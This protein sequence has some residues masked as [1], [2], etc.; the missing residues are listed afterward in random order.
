M[1]VGDRL[2]FYTDGLVENSGADG[3]QITERTIR[4][5]M[6][7]T[8]TL[9]EL[10]NSIE[11]EILYTWKG[12]PPDDDCAYIIMEIKRIGDRQVS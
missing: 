11:Q 4:K 12:H 3:K 10:R 6:K 5:M 2:F 1:E 8:K 7:S 9:T